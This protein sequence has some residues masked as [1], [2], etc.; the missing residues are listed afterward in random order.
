MLK[1]HH[2]EIHPDF[3]Q[4][5]CHKFG[6]I[7]APPQASPYLWTK[8]FDQVSSRLPRALTATCHQVDRSRFRAVDAIDVLAH[9]LLLWL[10]DL[11]LDVHGW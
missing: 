7:A 11:A 1:R 8:L 4:Q 2:S 6:G 9:Q 3:F 5:N 10:L